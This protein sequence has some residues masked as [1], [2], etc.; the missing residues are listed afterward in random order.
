MPKPTTAAVAPETTLTTKRLARNQ[1][2][3]EERAVSS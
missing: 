1:I 2:V 3:T